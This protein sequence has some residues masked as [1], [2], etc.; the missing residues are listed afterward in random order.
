[1]GD[2][3]V[4]DAALARSVAV[5]FQIASQQ[6]DQAAQAAPL[7]RK[8]TAFAEALRRNGFLDLDM[9]EIARIVGE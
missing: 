8:A 1:M 6:A 9:G 5:R 4:G 2:R 3:K 7:G